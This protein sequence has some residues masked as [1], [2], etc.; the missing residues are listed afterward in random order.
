VVT[1]VRDG[2]IVYKC[3]LEEPVIFEMKEFGRNNA[4]KE[5]T[6]YAF[7]TS[8]TEEAHIFQCGFN[9]DGCADACGDDA[10]KTKGVK[11]LFTHA[12]RQGVLKLIAS[13]DGKDDS[14]P[15]QQDVQI[16]SS[17]TR[18]GN[19]IVHELKPNRS[20]WFHVVKGEVLHNK[21]HLRTGDGAGLTEETAVSFTSKGPAEILIFDLCET[22]AE[23]K[24][25]SPSERGAVA[26]R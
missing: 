6:Q 11:K 16:Y 17:Y 3:H 7:N 9:L 23:E 20:A 4:D 22:K 24:E 18:D 13:G 26:T 5:T 2:M 10:P 15:I 8:E 19:H 12:E 21:V 1:Y 14:L 25:H